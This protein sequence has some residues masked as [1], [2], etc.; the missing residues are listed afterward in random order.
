LNGK[1][2]VLEAKHKELGEEFSRL[3]YRYD[4]QKIELDNQQVII[5]GL[6]SQVDILKQQSSASY[7]NYQVVQ[8]RIKSLKDIMD[9]VIVRLTLIK[10]DIEKLRAQNEDLTEENRKLH[11]RAAGGFEDLTPRPNYKKIMEETLLDFNVFNP[12]GKKPLKSTVD[13]TTGLLEKVQILQE[14][15]RNHASGNS[16]KGNQTTRMFATRNE[17]GGTD[18]QSAFSGFGNDSGT[19]RIFKG[20]QK[21]EKFGKPLKINILTTPQMNNSMRETSEN[22]SVISST[23]RRGSQISSSKRASLSFVTP[24]PKKHDDNSP[25]SNADDLS[26]AAIPNNKYA[27]STF[28]TLKQPESGNK[29]PYPSPS[30]RSTLNGFGGEALKETQELLSHVAQAKLDLKDLE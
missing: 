26:T 27:K 1:H 24:D 9:Q 25:L 22:N 19:P 18:P 7:D 17:S 12:T 11:V 6:E 10:R 20:S 3:K 4:K 28:S 14:K 16:R 21:R 30:P 29:T 5:Q 15:V 2:E 8:G 13:I 23:S